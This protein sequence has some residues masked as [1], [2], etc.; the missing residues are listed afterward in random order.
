MM[1]DMSSEGLYMAHRGVD[2][3][4]ERYATKHTNFLIDYTLYTYSRIMSGNVAYIIGEGL[5]T[6]GLCEQGN[7]IE[8]KRVQHILSVYTISTNRS[9]CTR[10]G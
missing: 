4:E 2:T 7:R 1:A 9:G 3:I 5:H 6:V 10:I 8:A